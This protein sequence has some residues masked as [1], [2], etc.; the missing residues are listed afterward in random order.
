MLDAHVEA[1]FAVGL[2]FSR[3]GGFDFGGNDITRRWGATPLHLTVLDS[4]A[5]VHA[6]HAGHAAI[7]GPEGALYARSHLSALPA[8]SMHCFPH[9]KYS[10]M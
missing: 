1:G 7:E 8:I 10:T 9:V 5:G 2:P 3:A 4:C 6:S